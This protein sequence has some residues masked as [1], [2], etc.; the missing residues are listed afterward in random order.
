MEVEKI[1]RMPLPQTHVDYFSRGKG[2]FNLSFEEYIHSGAPGLE[3]FNCI[4]TPEKAM[5]KL[6]PALKETGLY[7]ITAIEKKGVLEVLPAGCTK[8]QMI[9]DFCSLMGVRTEDCA[10][11]GDGDN[12]IDMLQTVGMGVAMGGAGE[13]VKAIADRVTDGVENDGLAAFIEKEI[14]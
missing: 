8:G 13:N 4:V 2:V 7:E 9:R 5:K 1:S 11:F 3:K 6:M 12:D 10:A 14:L